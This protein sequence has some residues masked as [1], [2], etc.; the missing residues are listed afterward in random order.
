[1]VDCR[2]AS[3]FQGFDA[4]RVL[5][6]F[7]DNVVWDAYNSSDFT[8]AYTSN[9][10][11]TLG[12]EPVSFAST[13]IA[14]APSD[15]NVTVT[16]NISNAGAPYDCSGRF[17]YLAGELFTTTP[18]V[19]AGS[20]VTLTSVLQPAIFCAAA[21]TGSISIL[22]GSAVVAT[23]S[24][25]GRITRLTVPSVGVGTHTYTASYSGDANYDPLNYGSVSLSAYDSGI[26]QGAEDAA[27][28]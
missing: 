21:P 28:L 15:T 9:A 1:M 2:G 25:S 11:F 10:A 27:A 23:A 17:V 6:T 20:S 8:S 19:A 22:E 13:L 16:N 18:S 4:S 24:V 7:M 3:T 12:P 26:T 5:T 14:R